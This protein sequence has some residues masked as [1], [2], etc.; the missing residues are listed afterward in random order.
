MLG[1][2]QGRCNTNISTTHDGVTLQNLL[3]DSSIVRNT[4]KPL[5]LAP[6][7]ASNASLRENPTQN[8][9]VR[10][11]DSDFQHDFLLD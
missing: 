5:R 6:A 1:N 7:I 4:C 11:R 9:G 8:L 3:R 10:R 2:L